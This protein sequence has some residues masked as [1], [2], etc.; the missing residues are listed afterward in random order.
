MKNNK[1]LEL[2]TKVVE[3]SQSKIFDEAR[4]EWNITSTGTAEVGEEET[5]VCGQTHLHYLF[6]ITNKNNGNVLY[7]IGSECIKKFACDDLDYQLKIAT[8]GEKKFVNKGK[9]FD[10]LTYG[11]ICKNHVDYIHFLKQHAFKAKYKK[12]IQYYDFFIKNLSI[13]K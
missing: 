9:R 6:E 12:L 5:C 10:G 4:Y 7:P 11:E 13:K 3:S 8:Y 1:F 2:A